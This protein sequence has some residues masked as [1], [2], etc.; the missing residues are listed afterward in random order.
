MKT[1]KEEVNIKELHRLLENLINENKIKFRFYNSFLSLDLL[2][3]I[4]NEKDNTIEMEF[5]DIMA[6]HIEELKELNKKF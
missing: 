2:E 6:E 1:N 5:R 4:Y 3:F